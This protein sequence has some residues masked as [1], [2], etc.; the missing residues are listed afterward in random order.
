MT[1]K[2]E[3]G[4]P[5]FDN[6]LKLNETPSPISNN[7]L[8]MLNSR[9]QAK[10]LAQELNFRSITESKNPNS[11]HNSFP[12]EKLGQLPGNIKKEA[13]GFNKITPSKQR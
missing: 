1:R 5:E 12:A 9:M 3:A 11:N 13:T 8:L 10:E 2:Q 7:D 4:H 6:E